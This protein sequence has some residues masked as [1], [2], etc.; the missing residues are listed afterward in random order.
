MS[1]TPR[2]GLWF[3]GTGKQSVAEHICRAALIGYALSN[4]VPKADKNRVVLLCLIHDLGEGRTSDLNYVHQKYGRLSESKAVYDIASALPFG[5]EISE[6][7]GEAKSRKSLEAQLAKDADTLEW[8][9][10]MREES[11]RG[12]AKA[13]KW[14]KIAFKRLKTPIAKKIGQLLLAT[15]P[16]D[17]WFNP[18]DKWY[19]TRSPK[20]RKWKNN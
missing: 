5:S 8:L 2:S 3:L 15:H 10:T 7:Y 18:K 11:S 4:L 9:T 13:E 1:K 14:A 6:I 16:D 20:L 19:V 12:N 17:W